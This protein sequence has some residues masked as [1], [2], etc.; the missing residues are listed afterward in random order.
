MLSIKLEGQYR[1]DSLGRRLKAATERKMVELT[2]VM[3]AKVMENVSG[4][5][6]QKKSGELAASIRKHVDI[7]GEPLI[8]EVYVDPVTPK[9][10]ALER[11]GD[12][13][14]PIVPTK[15]TVLKFYWEK[16]GRTVYL[17]YVN[18]P[19]SKEFAYLAIAL[20]EMEEEVPAGFRDAI[21]AAW[22]EG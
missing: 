11:G 6:L 2:D 21:Y 8:G 19:P 13:F 3:Y 1:I 10:M 14:Y 17:H 22:G 4:K 20:A 18:H 16:L 15:A 5:I 9:A 7:S 12:R